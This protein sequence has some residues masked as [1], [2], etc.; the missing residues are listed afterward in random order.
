LA[1]GAVFQAISAPSASRRSSWQ[2][3]LAG[4]SRAGCPLR[5][6]NGF[7]SWPTSFAMDSPRGILKDAARLKPQPSIIL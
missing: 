5:A 7:T 4:R 3:L 2:R 6:S 1:G